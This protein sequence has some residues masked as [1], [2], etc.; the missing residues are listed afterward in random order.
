MLS[1]SFTIPGIP[2]Q[3]G[4]KTF[5]RA[6]FGYEA[7]KNLAPWRRDAI[8]CARDAKAEL[9]VA[10]SVPVFTE[11]I[12][13]IMVAYFPRPQSHYGTGRNAGVLKANAPIWHSSAPDNDKVQRALGDALTQSGLIKDDRL[14]VHWDASKLYGDARMEVT[15]QTAEALVLDLPAP[16]AEQD[17][18]IV[19]VDLDALV[20]SHRGRS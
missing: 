6:G 11:A 4:S 13:V 18:L 7:N 10:D 16:V 3:Q 9:G 20:A 8:A 1:V 14:I 15:V 2:Q 12:E 17:A 5:T 19:D